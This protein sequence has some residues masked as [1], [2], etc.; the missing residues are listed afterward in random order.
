MELERL[1]IWRC[2]CPDKKNTEK[3]DKLSPG[4]RIGKVDSDKE[5]VE[6][7]LESIQPPSGGPDGASGGPGAGGPD[8]GA[9]GTDETKEGAVEA[10][11]KDEPT[12]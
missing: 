11:K 6:L 10:E 7:V 5:N 12:E 1:T 3:D 8:A 9:P 2:G 4:A